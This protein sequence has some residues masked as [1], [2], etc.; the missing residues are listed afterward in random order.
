M[1]TSKLFQPLKVGR[2]QVDHRIAMAPLTRFRCDEQGAP[3]PIMTE[4]YTQRCS[5][6]GTLIIAEAVSISEKHYAGKHAP[7]IWTR[8]QIDAW[9]DVVDAIHAKGCYVYCQIFAPGR[10]NAGRGITSYSSSAVPLDGAEAPQE[11]TEADIEEVIRDFQNAAKNAIEAGFD[12]VE[13]H[14]A[15]GYLIDQFV[16]DTCN[17]R[18]DAWGGS[19]EN[20]SRFGFEAVKAVVD[21]VGGDRTAIRLS[22]WSLFQGMKMEVSAAE[23]QFSDLIRR[24]KTLKLAYLHLIESRVVNHMDCDKVEGL[25]FAFDIWQNQSPILIAGGLNK[26]KA[27][28]AVD[29]EYKDFDVV[30]VFGRYFLST[31]DLV[32]RLKRGLEPNPYDRQTFYTPVQKEGY[33]DYPFSQEFLQEGS[34]KLQAV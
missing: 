14:G 27:F 24:L 13:L 7:G 11:M 30:V 23:A 17:K 16:Q 18:T 21:A 28:K 10:A 4:Y 15:N 1:A 22:P 26:E 19:Y 8:A 25:E 32:Y 2:L 12:G 20:R 31:P 9:R 34:N 33:I 5:T 3:L 29:K 6:P